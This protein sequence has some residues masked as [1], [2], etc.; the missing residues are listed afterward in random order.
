MT[1]K[2]FAALGATIGGA[3]GWWAGAH[4]GTMTAFIVS[5]VATGFGIFYGRRLAVH[6]G[7]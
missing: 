6:M 3:V 2:L 5:T 4:W 1:S 7:Y